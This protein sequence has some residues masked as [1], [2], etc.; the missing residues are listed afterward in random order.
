MLGQMVSRVS[1]K[2]KNVVLRLESEGVYFVSVK[3]NN[4]TVTKKLI[5]FQLV[6]VSINFEGI[7]LDILLKQI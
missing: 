5:V 7:E 3:S 6:G 2:E 4:Q 1:P